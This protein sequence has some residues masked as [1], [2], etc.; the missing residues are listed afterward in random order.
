MNL[1]T[2]RAAL[3]AARRTAVFS[4]AGLSAESGIATFRGNS[5]HALWRQFNPM[6]LASADGFEANPERVI[7]WYNWRRGTLA[8]AQP[9]AAHR[10]LARHPALVQITQNV[11]DLL[12]RAGVPAP[13]VLHLHGTIGQDRCQA[14]SCGHAETVDLASPPPLRDCPRCGAAR[15]RPAVVWFGEMLPQNVWSEAQRICAQ[16]DCLIVV[17]TSA[18]VYPAAGLIE[19]AA[20]AGSTVVTVNTEPSGS[21]GARHLELVGP[22]SVILPQLLDGLVLETPI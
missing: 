20:A 12:E 9:N 6:E 3:A 4:G 5:E 14:A 17:G 11:D 16:L 18:T 15:M 1:A 10:A 22:A 2:A 8:H 19:Q 21:G 7:D 13:H